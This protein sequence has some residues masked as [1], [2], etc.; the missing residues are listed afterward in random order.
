SYI[1]QRIDS[2]SFTGATPSHLANVMSE[3]RL[4]KK[5]SF[6]QNF[7]YTEAHK[8]ARNEY[9]NS[10]RLDLG[11]KWKVNESLSFSAWG[12]NLLDPQTLEY[13]DASS[14]PAELPRSFYAQLEW[15]F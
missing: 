15:K 13:S 8:S 6:F 10:Y 2:A 11:L 14:S 7:Y 3:V 12:L 1:E 4:T 9:S 5:V